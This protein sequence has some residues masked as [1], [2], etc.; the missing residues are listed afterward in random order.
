ME[1]RGDEGRVQWESRRPLP[2]GT[3]SWVI[4]WTFA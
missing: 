4:N 2:V 1:T 3:L